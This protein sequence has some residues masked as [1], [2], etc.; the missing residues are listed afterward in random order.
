[1][2]AQE[3]FEINRLDLLA[4]GTAIDVSA[5]SVLAACSNNTGNLI[6]SLHPGAKPPPNN[7]HNLNPNH[8]VRN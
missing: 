4:V 1:M 3:A 7:H 6:T 2:K 8:R 5:L